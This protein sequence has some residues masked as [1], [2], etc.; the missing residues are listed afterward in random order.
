VLLAFAAFVNGLEAQTPHLRGMGDARSFRNIGPCRTLR[1]TVDVLPLLTHLPH[2][3]WPDS[4]TPHALAETEAALRW[5]EARAAENGIHLVMRLLPP[6]PYTPPCPDSANGHALSHKWL[7]H[8]PPGGGPSVSQRQRASRRK[9]GPQLVPV[10]LLHPAGNSYARSMFGPVGGLG[11]AVYI[12]RYLLTNNG[13]VRDRPLRTVIAHEMLHLFGA[14]DLY[15]PL[16]RKNQGENWKLAREVFRTEIM[17]ASYMPIS[18]VYISP[19][20][21]YLVGWKHQFPAEQARYLNKR[22]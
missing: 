18:E 17:Y 15:F 7:Y 9:G 13:A 3:P 10:F 22:R 14:T 20:T 21:A 16:S 1:D 19:L 2:H 12:Y 5:L 6:E 4:A 8:R 11:E